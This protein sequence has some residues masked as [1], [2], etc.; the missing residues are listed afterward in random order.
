MKVLIVEDNKECM[1]Y[2]INMLEPNFSCDFETNG[3]GAIKAVKHIQY[4]FIIL[5][6]NI[7]LLNGMDVLKKLRQDKFHLPIIIVSADHKIQNKINAFNLGA[8]DYIVKPYDQSEFLARINAISRRYNGFSSSTINYGNISINVEEKIVSI[9]N[10]PIIFTT[11][12]LNVLQ[13]L[14]SKRGGL[15]SKDAMLE[16]LYPKI[17]DQ[18]VPKI[19]DV[20]ACKIRNKLKMAGANVDIKTI[21]SRGWRLEIVEQQI[22]EGSIQEKIAA[23]LE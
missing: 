18:P 22:D 21:W 2:F 12:E 9:N 7:P 5:D 19:L 20:F 23:S 16:E 8:D 10:Q 4:G 15:V 3:L 6:S 13:L 1:E 17:S 11:K 14:I